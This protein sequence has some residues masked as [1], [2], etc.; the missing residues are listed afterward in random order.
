MD[1]IHY[2]LGF[3]L[4]NG[5]GPARLDRM[6]AYFGSLEEAWNAG[7]G[8]LQLAGLDARTAAA[9]IEVR[10]KRD[11]EAEY[12]RIQARGVRLISRDDPA[13]P[14]LLRPLAN[15]PPL[16]YIRG[17]LA[18]N[19]RWAL[20]V[21]GTRRSTSYGR[22]ATRKL[23]SDLA[24]AGVTIVSGLALGIDGAAHRGAL[25]ATGGPPV[26]VVGSGLDVV[27]PPSHRQLWS[28]WPAPA[29]S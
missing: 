8:D 5:I 11:L 1:D 21:V 17:T 7:S 24:T 23:V 26:A 2:Y 6:I 12:T 27:Y 4:V 29:S 14:A 28:R 16:L 3:N 20:A 10:E 25:A 13:Y 9:L 22:D 19:D 18:E 15:T